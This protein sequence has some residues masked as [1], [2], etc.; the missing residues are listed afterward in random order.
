M[1]NILLYSP[2]LQNLLYVNLFFLFLIGVGS[3][4]YV[5]V[6]N[7]SV[8]NL[9][10]SNNKNELKNNDSSIKR[11]VVLYENKY[12]EGFKNL[13]GE[14]ILND[15]D[16]EELKDIMILKKERFNTKEVELHTELEDIKKLLKDIDDEKEKEKVITEIEEKEKLLRYISDK[17]LLNKIINEECINELMDKKLLNYKN[18][19]IIELTP[20]GNVFMRYNHESKMFEYFSNSTIPYRF[21]VAVSMK[22]V[23]VYRCK[24]I[25]KYIN[26]KISNNYNWKGRLWDVP[27]L[28]NESYNNKN[29]EISYNDYKLLRL[30]PSEVITHKIKDN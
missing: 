13:C 2:Y 5:C 9:W 19:Y 30:L 21:L 25:I 6:Y 27:L 20:L 28:K 17:E 3:G 7:V 16:R 12:E 23:I 11:V 18:N 8:S 22:Y 26:K 29:K 4:M 10:I 24:K 15:N 1:F 14:Y